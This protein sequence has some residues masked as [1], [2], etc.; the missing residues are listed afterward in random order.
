MW[1][2][3][4]ERWDSGRSRGRG[5]K[6]DGWIPLREGGREGGEREG[7]ARSSSCQDDLNLPSVDPDAA[8]FSEQLCLCV[9]V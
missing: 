2:V 4:R 3:G 8:F 7:E 1:V 6:D 5:N 9:C